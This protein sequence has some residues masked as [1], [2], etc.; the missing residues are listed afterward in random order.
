MITRVKYNL[1]FSMEELG[2]KY[3]HGRVRI[4]LEYEQSHWH[5][6]GLTFVFVYNDF[7]FFVKSVIFWLLHV[8][9]NIGNNSINVAFLCSGLSP[10][11][12]SHDF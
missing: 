1:P 7:F 4:C 9:N 3:L 2:A 8:I 10:K 11:I 6:N 12:D 5:L